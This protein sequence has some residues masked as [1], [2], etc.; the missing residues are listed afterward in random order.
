MPTHFNVDQFKQEIATRGGLSSGVFF[1]CAITHPSQELQFTESDTYLCKSVTLPS[2]VLDTVS[3][4]YYTREL[5]IPGARQYTPLT[6]NFHNTKDYVLRQRLYTWMDLFNSNFYNARGIKEGVESNNNGTSRNPT[7]TIQ[8]SSYFGS[9]TISAYS[10]SETPQLLTTYKFIDAY[11]TSIAGLQFSSEDD[12]SFQN[13]DVEFQYTRVIFNPGGLLGSSG[14]P[15][16]LV[17][18]PEAPTLPNSGPPVGYVPY[19]PAVPRNPAVPPRR[20]VGGTG[21][22]GATARGTIPGRRPPRFGGG[23]SGGAGGGA[24]F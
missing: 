23:R 16:G 2:E 24:S 8:T 21:S 13:F 1:Q 15:I 22:A 17:P 18:L 14:P 3:V 4:K 5:R 12:G 19:V 9:L 6:I 7:A 20:V 11:P 10:N